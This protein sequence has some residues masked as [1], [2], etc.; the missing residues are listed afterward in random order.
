MSKHLKQVKSK[1][2]GGTNLPQNS[3][4]FFAFIY[5][6]MRSKYKSEKNVCKLNKKN[7]EKNNVI[8]STSGVSKLRRQIGK[9]YLD[10]KVS[11]MSN[12]NQ[13]P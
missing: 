3:E 10:C 1:D 9:M 8:R 11:K 2:A 13:N 7:K 12:I 5:S 6:T 4:H